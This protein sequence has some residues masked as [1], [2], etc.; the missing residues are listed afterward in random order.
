[1][2]L[3]KLHVQ[4]FAQ[5]ENVEIDFRDV[6]PN[7]IIGA[8]EAGKSHL[9]K[10][11]YAVLFGLD[12]DERERYIPWT[13]EPTMLG[14]L[15]FVDESGQLV[16]LERN[17]VT[18]QVTIAEGDEAPW[19]VKAGPKDRVA[20]AQGYFECLER[21]LGFR[22]TKI[23]EATTFVE[24]SEVVQASM[25]GIA[26]EVKSLIT[27]S[28]EADYED[29]LKDLE[30]RL[31][32]LRKKTPQMK[33]PRELEVKQQEL[34]ELQ[35]GFDAASKQH[36]AIA[37]LKQRQEQ[38]SADIRSSSDL[39][40]KQQDELRRI[41][42]LVQR[43][44]DKARLDARFRE[45]QEDLDRFKA[46]R[47]AL[48]RAEKDRDMVA[49]AALKD[50]VAL[51]QLRNAV[52]MARASLS[53]LEARGNIKNADAAWLTALDEPVEVAQREV[54]AFGSR[55]G[56][57]AIS[58][59]SLERLDR[60]ARDAREQ[61]RQLR[62][63]GAT[64]EMDLE[65]LYG[66]NRAVE[67]ARARQKAA[68]EPG[69]D[70]R[71]SANFPLAGLAAL[72]T[73]AAIVLAIA[74]NPVAL[75][76]L[77]PAIGMLI[78]SFRSQ[79]PGAA[80][81]VSAEQARAA[82]ERAERARDAALAS[83]GVATVDEAITLRDRYR[84]A[85]AEEGKTK[86]DLDDALSQ[87]GVHSTAEA[88]VLLRAH[89][90]ALAALALA[91]NEW[92]ATLQKLGVVSVEDALE[93][94]QQYEAARYTVEAAEKTRDEVL[95]R[96]N[97]K[98]IE[99][100]IQV[101]ERYDRADADAGASEAVLAALGDETAVEA[102]WK[103]VR[104]KLAVAQERVERLLDGNLALKLQAPE[105]RAAEAGR[106][107]GSVASLDEKLKGLQEDKDTVDRILR[108]E[109]REEQDVAGLALQIEAVQADIARIK[110]QIQALEAAISAF[111]GAVQEFYDNCLD[112]VT[113]RTAHLLETI[114]DGRYTAVHLSDGALEPSVD[115]PTRAG[116]AVGD[117]SRGVCDQLY[118]SL[119][120]ALGEALAGGKVLPLILD[121]PFV[122]FDP[123]RLERALG[124]LKHL[125]QRTQVILFTCDPRYV[126][127]IDPV[128]ELG[129]VDPVAAA[130]EATGTA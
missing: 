130:V 93:L 23:F 47:E 108:T 45:L 11:L 15:D 90:A 18:N 67:D 46:Q 8:N 129:R 36:D 94:R 48:R 111:N 75:V 29:V 71:A 126:A 73:I 33:K 35:G 55:P 120:V 101:R 102:E 56:L 28:G 39:R 106:L 5:L 54:D 77:V 104:G 65:R 112:P 52:D 63:Q 115:A 42:D 41:A 110:L 3:R 69:P 87:L 37:G 16:G 9:M 97:V 7:L 20:A 30:K 74:V 17:F 62:E 50:K 22:D 82:V 66:L 14:R 19:S 114:T 80:T 125:V 83:F 117:L 85:V 24:Q 92:S 116:I 43:E 26:P 105:V 70:A 84:Q 6:T 61:V 107:E 27:G 49:V 96:L 1:M 64:G 89:D 124:L 32:G 113:D 57:G 58:A 81:T 98:T 79:Q 99:D 121:D 88:L 128:L 34:L 38:L 60:D 123:E 13:G 21:W 127:W 4:G 31:D 25:G 40:D 118:L 103:D 68:G 51:N 86:R 122:N 72:L 91:R 95:R 76:L 78:Y 100:A 2:R 119:R 12:K 44:S 59:A 53:G 10:A 109:G